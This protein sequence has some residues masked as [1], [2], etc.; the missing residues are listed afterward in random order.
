MWLHQCVFGV[1]TLCGSV[2]AQM[3]IV[4]M[5]WSVEDERWRRPPRCVSV[6]LSINDCPQ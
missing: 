2:C 6:P 4:M 1:D 3:N 5:L